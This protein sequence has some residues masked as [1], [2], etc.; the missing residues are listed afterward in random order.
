MIWVSSGLG[1]PEN[2]LSPLLVV[3]LP[4]ANS[5]LPSLR[6]YAQSTFSVTVT[7]LQVESLFS[8]SQILHC[9]L[10]KKAVFIAFRNIWQTEEQVN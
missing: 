10:E 7:R 4:M 8:A 1:V 5:L 3:F 6:I 9:H 2:F